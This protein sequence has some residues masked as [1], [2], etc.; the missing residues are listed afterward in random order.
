MGKKIKEI[1]IRVCFAKQTLGPK[2]I[3]SAGPEA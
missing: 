3:G 2:Q 1:G